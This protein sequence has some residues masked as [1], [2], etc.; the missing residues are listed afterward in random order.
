MKSSNSKIMPRSV[1]MMSPSTS[2]MIRDFAS[3]YGRPLKKGG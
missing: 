1:P 3:I 2:P